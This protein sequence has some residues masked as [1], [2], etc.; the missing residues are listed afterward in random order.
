M[1]SFFSRF[2]NA[3]VLI[4]VLLAQTIGL[5]IQVRR[6]VGSDEPDGR[7]IF[8]LRYWTAGA[9]T[10][11]ERLTQHVGAGI[12]GT[13]QSYVDLR[14]ARQQNNALQQQIAQM[15]L[16][17][18]A[19]A[20]D[21]IQGHRLQAL[22]NFQQH[23]IAKTV[24]AQVIGTSGSDLSR[25]LTLDK[26]SDDGLK[27]DMAVITPDGIV[28]KLRDVFPHTSQLLLLNDQ[29]AGA[30]VVLQTTRIRAI[31]RGTAT[32]RLQISNLTADS[33]IKPGETVLTSGGDLVYPRGLN[34]GVI[35]SV[36]ADPDHQ[37]YTA[38]VVKPTANL[39]QLE[40]VLVVT[41]TQT[42]ISP[43]AQQDLAKGA[44]TAEA[45]TA[46]ADTRRA[47]DLLSER[48]PS[49][50][51]IDPTAPDAKSA[52]PNAPATEGGKEP[53]GAVPK[54]LPTLHADHF[55]PGT[56]PPASTLTPGAP[57]SANTQMQVPSTP[58]PR[59][60]KTPVAPESSPTPT[61]APTTIPEPPQ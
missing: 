14:H 30:G 24:A 51:E 52:D 22:L 33:R 7:K 3:L 36:A 23:Y 42:M 60:S 4:A 40:E 18:A 59:R 56:T 29:T 27:P 41:G 25:M 12:R 17:E 20:E 35:E 13:W 32:G 2:K 28:G 34:V 21:A 11:F 19:F 16:E 38:I 5:A 39:F 31:V 37:P 26:G 6:P 43:Q 1:E 10:P 9:L 44:A 47:A 15:R 48:L 49:L 50:H 58:T 46:Q 55:T 53:G 54:P 45:I 57:A 61:T 8:L